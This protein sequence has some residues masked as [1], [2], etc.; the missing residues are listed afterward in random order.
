MPIYLP[1]LLESLPHLLNIAKACSIENIRTNSLYPHPSI[2]VLS[3][4]VRP[5]VM[6]ESLEYR[7]AESTAHISSLL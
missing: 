2:P 6:I 3:V 7:E 1:H 5:S 4:C